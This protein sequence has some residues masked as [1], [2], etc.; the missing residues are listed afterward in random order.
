M[1]LAFPSLS[2]LA[3]TLHSASQQ[4]QLKETSKRPNTPGD[5]YGK[6]FLLFE[7]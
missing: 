3:S 5:V 2:M 1:W 7:D 4:L 6:E